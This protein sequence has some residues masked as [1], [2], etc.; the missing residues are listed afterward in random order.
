M[1][2]FAWL[3]FA[4]SFATFA[5]LLPEPPRPSQVAAQWPARFEGRLLAPLTPAPEDAALAR[6][7]PG[8]VS[9]FSDGRRQIVL[10]RLTS[11]TRTLHPARNCFGALGYAIT[12]AP[13][14]IGA[15]GQQ[16]ACFYATRRGKTSHVC[17]QVRDAEGRGFAD[18]S[19]WYWSAL[20][21]RS[22]GPWIA[23]MTVERTH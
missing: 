2:R 23:V 1:M 7:F 9:R 22:R 8:K 16:S 19:G 15:D 18:I 12:P 21:G 20:L 10:R 13:I 4:T 6:S 5:S 3:A 11:A 14:R 17:E